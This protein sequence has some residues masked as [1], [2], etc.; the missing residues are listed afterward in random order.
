MTLEHADMMALLRD[1]SPAARS[2]IA[3][4]LAHSFCRDRFTHKENQLAIDIFRLL[5]KDTAVQVRKAMADHLYDNPNVPRDIMV[6]LATDESVVSL[7]VLEHSLVLEDEDLIQ[8]IEAA[9]EVEKWMA[10]ARRKHISHKVSQSLIATKHQKTL[11]TLFENSGA[12]LED[13]DIISVLSDYKSNQNIMEALVCRGGLSP[14]IAEKIYE[15]M[16]VIL[17]KNLVKRHGLGWNASKDLANVAKEAM[18]VR[19]LVPHMTRPEIE[20]LLV[21]MHQQKRLSFGLLIRALCYGEIYFFEAG[22]AEL[23]GLS[24]HH[25]RILMKDSAGLGVEAILQGKH[26]PVN[27]AQG[28]SIIYRTAC[29]LTEQGK[30]RISDFSGQVIDQLYANGYHETVENMPYFISILKQYHVRHTLH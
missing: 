15:R 23:A 3:A 13:L 18:V 14:L 5:V 7:L 9:Q 25:A 6:S 17:K 21:Q 4:E 20:E 29:K 2:H 16:S 22:M 27:F 30:H 19:F 26:M 12:E 11:L 1:P 28:L 24:V 10:I 8:L